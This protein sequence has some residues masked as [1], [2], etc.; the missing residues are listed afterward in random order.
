MTDSF[1]YGNVS[2]PLPAALTHPLLQDADPALYYALDFLS[3][4]IATYAGARLIAEANAIGYPVTAAVSMKVPYEPGAYLMQEGVRLP[5]LSIA[6]R[7]AV[8]DQHSV[9]R[10]HASTTW[11]LSYVLPPMSPSQAQK[12]QPILHAIELLIHNR[13]EHGHDPTYTPPGAAI[14]G[15][16]W[17]LAGV[18]S[19]KSTTTTYAGYE[20][21]GELYF[22][23]LVMMLEAREL[24]APASGSPLQGMDA[25]IAVLAPDGTTTPPVA[26]T[27]SNTYVLP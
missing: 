3:A 1:K 11:A 8:N 16:V 14:D 5:L 6:R 12:L 9:A 15:K 10:S 13:L 19:V 20:G 17:A 21:T 18:E 23:A 22:P 24:N 2:F 26:D 25:G 4:M 7:S 27:N